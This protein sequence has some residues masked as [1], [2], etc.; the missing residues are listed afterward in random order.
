MRPERTAGVLPV[1]SNP[2][3]NISPLPLG[4]GVR[5][6]GMRPLLRR[7]DRTSVQRQ[8]T[9]PLAPPLAPPLGGGGFCRR[10]LQ[11][12]PVANAVSRQSRRRGRSG[13]FSAQQG[14]PS[15][16]RGQVR[17]TGQAAVFAVHLPR[18][19]SEH[20]G[21]EYKDY[22][23]CRAQFASYPAWP[24]GRPLARKALRC[25]GLPGSP[26]GRGRAVPDFFVLDGTVCPVK[27][28]EPSTCFSGPFAGIRS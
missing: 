25:K 4:E 6:R 20:P 10:P 28:D 2:H 13:E 16:G 5:G 9:P 24:A 21:K 18:T 26:P 1:R 8:A 3:S 14:A 15:P 17:K 27:G 23:P 22:C 12:T 19:D 7:G 11:M